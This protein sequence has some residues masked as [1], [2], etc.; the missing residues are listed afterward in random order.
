[1]KNYNK[2][3]RAFLATVTWVT[4]GV[5]TL[6]GCTSV[7]DTLGFEYIPDNQELRIGTARLD[8]AKLLF[9]T[10]LYQTDSVV[11]SN[12]SY[13]YFGQDR[14]D[15][16][17]IRSAGFLSQYLCVTAVDS[18]YFGYRP[19]FD[20]ALLLL[21]IQDHGRDT[22]TPQTFNV[23]EVISNDYLTEEMKLPNGTTKK[24][25]SIFYCGFNPDRYVAQ[26]PLFTFTFPDGHSSGPMSSYVRMEPT[27]AGRE[28]I[29]RLMISDGTTPADKEVKYSIYKNNNEWVKKFKGLYITP[30][31]AATGTLF[32][33][34]LST[35][36]FAIYGRN[37]RQTDPTLIKDTVGA[38]YNFYYKDATTGKQSINMVRH[39]YTGTTIHL[40][41]AVETNTSRPLS[42][43]I[44]AAGMGGVISEITFT[45]GLFKSIEAII[46]K[47]NAADPA[48]NRPEE[49]YSSLAFNQ[50]KLMIYFSESDHDWTKIIPAEITRWMNSSISRLGLYTNYKKLKGI[51]DYNYVYEKNYGTKLAYGGY[52]NRSQGCYVMN[53][54]AY[55]QA[56]WNSYLKAKNGNPSAK[57]DLSKLEHRSIYLG[58]EAYGIFTLPHTTVQGM[59]SSA[60]GK[61][62]AMKLEI[63]YTM[64][65]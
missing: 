49:H 17:G 23:Y 57:V 60:E 41:D 39:D 55:L 43:K 6:V 9:E 15:T 42:E 48:T 10:R 14:N 13:G 29:R 56:L 3:R 53:I 26:E 12:I 64:V 22:L 30:S 46:A 52:I 51:D 28:F 20:S 19:I 16:T 37:R 62:N 50:A 45:E 58:P 5:I 21:S 7:D 25:D 61:A 40:A 4:A 32:A 11:S 1:M 36:G 34:E 63:T 24:N 38:I 65:K 59:G 31:S 44:Y 8:E 33:T 27:R 54:S 18:G 35:S 47:E 2:F